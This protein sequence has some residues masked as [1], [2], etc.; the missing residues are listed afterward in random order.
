MVV[1]PDKAFTCTVG[2]AVTLAV[3]VATPIAI[4]DPVK[5]FFILYAPNLCKTNPYMVK[6]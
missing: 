3:A 4:S 2:A 6:F 1:P 5:N